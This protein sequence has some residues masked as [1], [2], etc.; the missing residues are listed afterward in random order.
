[1]S[2]ETLIELGVASEETKGIAF[3]EVQY[4]LV[5]CDNRVKTPELGGDC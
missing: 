5:P 4:E 2:N 3:S 1:M